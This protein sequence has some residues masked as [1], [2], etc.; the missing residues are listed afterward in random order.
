MATNG[1]LSPEKR[2]FIIE[3]FNEV[4][5]SFDGV[6]EVQDA[7]RPTAGGASSFDAV[8]GT[9][10]D[11]DS[12]GFHYGIRMT[13]TPRNFATLPRS[14]AMLCQETKCRCIQ[15]EPAY[16]GARGGHAEPDADQA[17]AFIAA[18]LEAFEV[19]ARAGRTLF[20]SGARPW[21]VTT[22]FCRAARDSLVVTPNGSLVG[23]FEIHDP[24]HPLFERFVWGNLAAG[25]PEPSTAGR[26]GSAE[27]G[28]AIEIDY[29]SVGAL[30]AADRNRRQECRGCFCY[31]HCAG[32]CAVR[33]TAA[34]RFNP[35]RCLV[36]RAITQE[37]IAWY[38][39]AGGGV[40]RGDGRV[41]HDWLVS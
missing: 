29:G 3:N 39:A 31:W 32:D 26:S 15:V 20:Y 17:A 25:V 40:W 24:S 2:E 13:V 35:G 22:T 23:C 27:R 14:V 11:F 16:S 33:R 12:A 19:S 10:R 36:N 18:F 1:M 28:P 21:S 7:Q 34:P 8:M 37:L 5:L 38:V 6:R 4:C 9:I 41:D 30:A